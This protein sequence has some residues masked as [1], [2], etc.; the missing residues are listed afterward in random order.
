MRI[1]SVPPD[2]IVPAAL[3]RRVDERADALDDLALERGELRELE[4]VQG[5]A[6]QVPRG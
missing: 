6:E 1:D 3:G 4:R 5:V 2:V